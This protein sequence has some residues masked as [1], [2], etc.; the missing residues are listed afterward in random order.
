MIRI[1]NHFPMEHWEAM[2]RFLASNYR[3]DHPICSREFFEW[4]FKVDPCTERAGIVCAWE[5]DELLGILGY[6]SCPVMWGSPVERN[7]A[8]FTL[9]WMVSP[10]APRGLGLLLLRRVKAIYPFLLTVN[11]SPIGRPILESTGWT[12]LEQV[13]R[14][15]VVLNPD[16]CTEMLFNGGRTDYL[17]QLLFSAVPGKA[18][19]LNVKEAWMCPPVYRPDWKHYPSLAFGVVRSASHLQWRYVDHPSFQYHITGLGEPEKPA[20]CVYRIEDTFGCCETKVGRIVDFFF[21]V[22]PEGE[23]QGLT[24]LN[25]VLSHLQQAGCAFADFFCTMGRFGSLFTELGGRLESKTKQVLPVRL[26]PVEK[27]VR[28]QNVCISTPSTAF[29]LHNP[30]GLYITKSDIDGDSP[31]FLHAT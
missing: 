15:V 1:E 27:T 28:H 8:A 4:Q 25:S 23:L 21:P 5:G 19:P 14:Y 11:A 30:S 10:D 17:S 18:L 29:K 20:I 31:A 6:V 13:P 2:H 16:H 22:D 12:C 9:Y 26:T 3:A 24:L 7:D